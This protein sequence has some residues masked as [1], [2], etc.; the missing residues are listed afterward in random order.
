MLRRHPTRVEERA[1][2]AA[3]YEA[4]LN[5]KESEPKLQNSF[6]HCHCFSTAEDLNKG[7][8]ERAEK[9]MSGEVDPKQI[10]TVVKAFWTCD[11]TVLDI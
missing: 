10:T 5:E 9:I 6:I 11:S 8:T 4:Y 7:E 1:D 2:V 3:E